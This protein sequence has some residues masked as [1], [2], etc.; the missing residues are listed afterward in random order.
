MKLSFIGSSTSVFFRSLQ[1]STL[2]VT[3]AQAHYGM[4]ILP[5]RWYA[6]RYK[7]NLFLVAF[8]TFQLVV[9][10]WSNPKNFRSSV[11]IWKRIS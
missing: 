11:A 6:G 8:T 9:W 3:Q 4:V 5:I 7:A 10:N 2:M 1:L